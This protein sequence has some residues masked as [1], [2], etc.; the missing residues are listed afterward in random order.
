[1]DTLCYLGTYQ[2]TRYDTP[3][4]HSSKHTNVYSRTVGTK[5]HVLS[6]IS[7][8]TIHLLEVGDNR[9]PIPHFIQA[10]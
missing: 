4:I 2:M 8:K 1:M 7:E 6:I 5:V 9:I 10:C 3:S